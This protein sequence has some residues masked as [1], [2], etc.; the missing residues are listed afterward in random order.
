MSGPNRGGGGGEKKSPKKISSSLCHVRTFQ[1]FDWLGWQV[2]WFEA[3]EAI[4]SRRLGERCCLWCALPPAGVP[5]FWAA[6]EYR[7][8]VDQRLINPSR[9]F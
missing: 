7:D 4:N 9:F 1:R 5:I 2:R 8:N 6:G 3:I